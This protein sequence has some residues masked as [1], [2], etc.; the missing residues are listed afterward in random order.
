MEI[1]NFNFNLTE[2]L[3]NKAI[4]TSRIQRERPKIEAALDRISSLLIGLGLR[5]GLRTL[6]DQVIYG[7]A[8]TFEQ[9]GLRFS[10]ATYQS[11]YRYLIVDG[12]TE[13]NPLDFYVQSGTCLFSN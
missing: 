5:Q 7:P 11:I 6:E 2:E 1:K 3:K 4:H 10:P 13:N 9:V 12:S 8:R